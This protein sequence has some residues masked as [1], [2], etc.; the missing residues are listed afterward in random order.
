M[1][2]RTGRDP[3]TGRYRQISRTFH[4]L[5]KDAQMALNELAVEADQGKLAN[6]NATFSQLAEQWLNLAKPG[7]GP[8]TLR[9]YRG[10]LDNHILPALGTRPLRQIQTADLD[11]LYHS[12]VKRKGLSTSSVRRVHTVVHRAFQQGVRWKWVRENPASLVSL[13]KLSRHEVTPPD[14]GQ[15]KQLLAAAA[16]F[17]PVFGRLLHLA[18]T[19]GAR[20]GE[21]CALKWK[22]VDTDSSAL[23]IE[24]AIIEI[25]G[26]GW[27]EKDT[28]THASRRIALDGE[29]L[30]VLAEQRAYADE[31]AR[32]AGLSL[33]HES[34]VF[35]LEPDG[36]R[37]FLP[38]YVTRRFEL[39]RTN[40]GL[41]Q[42]RLHDFRHFAATR[43]ISSGV[44]VRT[45]AGRLG[46]SNASMTLQVYSH[47]VE[48]TDREAA[49]LIGSLVSNASP[50]R[51]TKPRPL[52]RTSS[53]TQR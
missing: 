51:S 8:Q 27:L 13:P 22:H 41:T 37:P 47:F 25:P 21:L 23:L 52:K 46:H 15:V 32:M 40:L 28:K 44:S 34:Y 42:I 31:L 24:H 10:L 29:S 7:L 36:Q 35:S 53:S 50:K 9:S 16:K 17:D 12:L 1:R 20:R 45:V 43:L 4:G 2:V 38:T 5:K 49:E 18:A 48:A 39:V 11:S 30:R 6:T 3:L 26:G 33:M 14:V 19:T